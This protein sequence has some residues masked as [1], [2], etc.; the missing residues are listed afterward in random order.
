MVT[1]RRVETP[2]R[3]EPMVTISMAKNENSGNGKNS[4]KD[5]G[6]GSDK[7]L[8]TLV[9]GQAMRTSEAPSDLLPDAQLMDNLSKKQKK[10][11]KKQA[12]GRPDQGSLSGVT[13]TQSSVGAGGG[14]PNPFNIPPPTG[15]PS[16]VPVG[17]P[18]GP[19]MLQPSMQVS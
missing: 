8:Y 4:G 1:I 14:S 11:L 10:K 13:I 7:L 17:V 5:N 15:L 3:P 18:T 16:H 9:N 12:Q 19:K 2:G 6:N